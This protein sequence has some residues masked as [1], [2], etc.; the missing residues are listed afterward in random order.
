MRNNMI[1]PE[2]VKPAMA[3]LN[4]SFAL[5]L[6][7]LLEQESGVFVMVTIIR[8]KDKSIA[9]SMDETEF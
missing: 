5:I 3:R 7:H 8:T 4:G 9:R 6:R 1:V 2:K